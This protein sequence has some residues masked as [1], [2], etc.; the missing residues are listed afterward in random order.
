MQRG[1]GDV[2]QP[3]PPAGE[4]ARRLAGARRQPGALDRVRHGR[5]REPAR[6]ARRAARRRARF[7]STVSR[8][9]TLVSWNTSPSRRRTARRARAPRRGRR[10]GPLPRVGASSVASSSIAVVLPAPFGPSRPTSAPARHHRGRA[11]RARAR[12]RSRARA[13]RPRSA[14][15]LTPAA[16]RRESRGSDTPSSRSALADRRVDDAAGRAQSVQTGSVFAASPVSANAWQRQP[17]KSTAFRGQLRQGS[18]IQRR[19]ETP[20]TPRDSLPDP[21]ERVVPHVVEARAW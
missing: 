2:D 15:A 13:L 3:A 11:R 17:P 19:R 14:A 9:S 16:A 6:R 1:A 10:P 18:F 12:R 20:G 5:A 21:V 8:P 4:L 7:S